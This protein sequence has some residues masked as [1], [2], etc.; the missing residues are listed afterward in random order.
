M[1]LRFSI[2]RMVAVIAFCGVAFAAFRSPSNLWSSATF[3]LA[4]VAL[5]LALI[6]LIMERGRSKAYW[7]GFA[8]GGWIYFALMFTPWLS[9]M[10]GPRLLTTAVLDILYPHLVSK[11]SPPP[12]PAFGATWTAGVS[13]TA[14]PGMGGMPGGSPAG[15]GGMASM[16]MG[17][18]GMGG[19]PPPEPSRWA[20]WTEADRSSGLGTTVGNV[21]LTS[22]E[23]YRRIGHSLLTLLFAGLAGLF[24]RGCYDRNHAAPSPGA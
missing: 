16:M 2:G 15:S 11:E 20:I 19:P 8:L 21:Y 9:D 18:G 23:P 12:T 5:V 4:I 13:G 1:N 10:V 22:P 17:G 6:A 7:S 24:A 3:S 14:A